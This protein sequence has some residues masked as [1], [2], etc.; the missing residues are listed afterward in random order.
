MI[1]ADVLV[2]GAGPAG[3]AL[4]L[5]LVQ[6][7]PQAQAGRWR[8]VLV[9]RG[10]PAAQL[11]QTLPGAARGLL[12]DLG[13]L[14]SF[15][16]DGHPPSL[17][18]ASLWG[19]DRLERRDAFA[20][21]QGAGWRVDSARLDRRLVATA[22]QRGCRLIGPAAVTGIGRDA[23]AA[24][25][26]RVRIEGAAGRVDEVRCR[27]VVDATGRRATLAR[28]LGAVLQRLDKLVCDSVVLPPGA[29]TDLDGFALVEAAPGGWFYGGCAASGERLIAFHTDF[30]L[31]GRPARDPAAFLAAVSNTTLMRRFAGGSMRSAQATHV[32][33]V[34]AW[35]GRLAPCTGSGW[36]AVGDAACCFDPLS[37]Q[38]V[39]NALYGGLRLARA[40]A[41]DL[42]SGSGSGAAVARHAQE[43]DAVW[44]AYRRHHRLYCASETRWADMPF[45]RRRS[46]PSPSPSRASA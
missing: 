42:D 33:R 44:A 7:H 17:G 3:A 32:T 21:P 9:D 2:A 29:A 8:V 14:D 43:I 28:R 38:G 5:A 37:S 31:A 27:F 39:F 45:W 1:E 30:D 4:A 15:E 12:R 40:I 24:G 16:A 10:V 25:G 11:G 6:T 13:V 46:H 36:A 34:A 18:Q 23:G 26:W 35:S 20:D 41:S 22:V 19:C